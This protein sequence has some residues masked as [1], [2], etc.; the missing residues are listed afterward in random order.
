[1]IFVDCLTLV[2]IKNELI[3]GHFLLLVNLQYA[4]KL[5][6]N[7]SSLT[8]NV[9]VLMFYNSSAHTRMCYK[10]SFDT[11]LWIHFQPQ[12]LYCHLQ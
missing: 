5:H 12:L 9:D 2:E 8:C 11:L 3:N 10:L 4:P 7:V 1:M 6:P